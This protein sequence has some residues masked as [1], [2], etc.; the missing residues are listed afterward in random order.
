MS[1]IVNEGGKLGIIFSAAKWSGFEKCR[2]AVYTVIESSNMNPYDCGFKLENRDHWR[3]LCHYDPKKLCKLGQVGQSVFDSHGETFQ[4]ADTMKTFTNILM[5][6]KYAA[7]ECR[8]NFK[9]MVD[10]TWQQ[11]LKSGIGAFLLSENE[12]NSPSNRKFI[13]ELIIGK[14]N[15]GDP[16]L[17]TLAGGYEAVQDNECDS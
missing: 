6:T 2:L 7:D 4:M 9:N 14:S 3:H 8:A 1:A 17:N 10:T 16:R 12:V 11:R 15:E 5:V 13:L